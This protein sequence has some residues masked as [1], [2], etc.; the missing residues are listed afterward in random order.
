MN[1]VQLATI[2]LAGHTVMDGV[3]C[4]CGTP[5]CIC[6]PGETRIQRSQPN[7]DQAN[8]PSDVETAT[9]FD[10]SA[11]AMILML[12]LIVTLRMRF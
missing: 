11:G 6:G 2:A 5:N 10:P 4:D 1:S 3:Y 12:A 9:S 7:V 8:S